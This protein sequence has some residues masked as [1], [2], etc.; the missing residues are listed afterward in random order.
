VQLV[1]SKMLSEKEANKI[2]KKIETQLPEEKRDP[3]IKQLKSMSLKDLEQF[4]KK[5]K[6]M[7]NQ[8]CVFC[9]IVSKK[10]ES[11]QIDE[12]DSAIAVLEINPISKGH[13]LILPKKHEP[14]E[15]ISEKIYS[16]SK[17]IAKKLKEKLK[18]KDVE[19]ASL[20]YKGHGVINLI[21]V[22]DN[23]SIDSKR[24]NANKKELEEVLNLFQNNNISK[25][26]EEE[27]DISKISEKEVITEKNPWLPKRIP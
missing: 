21:P 1:N 17:K 12:T 19:I 22:Y 5:N 23:E 25:I 27:K 20:N 18:S 2:I 4:L 11:Y 3:I 7:E 15:D 14:L 8:E 6:L 10:I 24:Y 16:F 13:T 9:L 26:K